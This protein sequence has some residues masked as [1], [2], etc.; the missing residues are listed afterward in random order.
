MIA[1]MTRINTY[2]ENIAWKACKIFYQ[3]TLE[4]KIS[5]IRI[6][7]VLYKIRLLFKVYFI[8]SEKISKLFDFKHYVLEID[9]QI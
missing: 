6:Y 8:I 2:P 3:Y 7:I 5:G 1:R 9:K 4:Q